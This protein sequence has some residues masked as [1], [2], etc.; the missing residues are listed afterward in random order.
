MK[1]TGILAAIVIAMCILSC[2]RE[3][4]YEKEIY[5]SPE[6]VI[7]QENENVG[8][9]TD[10]LNLETRPGSVLITGIPEFRLTTIYKLNKD[11]KD[12][13]YYIGYNH[14]Y[15]NYSEIGYK[16]GNQWNNNFMPGLRA[17]YGFNMVNVSLYNIS[18]K[19]QKSLFDTPVI[20]KT[21]YYPS[22]SQDTL[23]NKPVK[24]DFYLVSAYDKDTNKD[25]LVNMND[26][27]HF[28]SFDLN[29][30][31]KKEI[32]PANYSVIS[33]EYDSANDYMFIFAQ[34]DENNNG[35]IEAKEKIHVFWIDLKNP[36][37]NG[38]SY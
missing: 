20:I 37:I 27:R 16:N 12:G 10:S 31:N 25:G 14:F 33:S 19:I 29:G 21:L 2:S 32:I 38:R 5:V 8:F 6:S 17:V 26:L 36:A 13:T 22:F 4:N 7:S 23:N 34:L 9:A 11:K 24:R 18:T 1:K 35:Q 3:K 30:L 15:S 28:Y